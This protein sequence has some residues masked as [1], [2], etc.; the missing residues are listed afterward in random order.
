MVWLGLPDGEKYFKISLFVLTESTNVTDRRTHT[1]T[2]T[3]WRLIRPCL[4]SRG[5]KKDKSFL[6]LIWL[7]SIKPWPADKT[8]CTKEIM[9]RLKSQ[10]AQKRVHQKIGDSWR[11]SFKTA[12]PLQCTIGVYRLR[13]LWGQTTQPTVSQGRWI[14]VLG[15]NR[16]SRHIWLR[17]GVLN[18][19]TAHLVLHTASP[20][21]SC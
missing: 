6:I 19:A 20:E 8:T 16:D 17:R 13:R 7:T 9:H 12:T 21:A 5:K 10:P 14:Q 3:A 2:N 4:A 11:T 15:K 18:G 1:Q